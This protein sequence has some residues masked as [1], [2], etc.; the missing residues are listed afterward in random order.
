M[1]NN[2]VGNIVLTGVKKSYGGQTVLDIPALTL[3]KGCAT[4]VLGPNGSGKSTLLKALAGLIPCEG[5]VEGLGQCAVMEQTPYMFDYSVEK[6]I[7]LGGADFDIGLYY[8]RLE[9]SRFMGRNAKRLSGGET[10]RVALLR[11][12]A[13][14]RSVL[15]LD[16][17]TA[18][19]DIRSCLLVEAVLGEL[20]GKGYTIIFS[21]HA[22]TQAQRLAQMAVMMWEGK[23]IEYS[24]AET[25]LNSPQS[26]QTR[27]F[28]EYWRH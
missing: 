19:A 8:E 6:N 9:L 10:Q 23:A 18:S 14:G 5:S 2:N 16:E 13:T 4:A 28:L 21:T 24:D 1:M 20:V 17:P 27:T 15:V 26:E 12:I 22:P 25:L 3:Q 11:A 7:A